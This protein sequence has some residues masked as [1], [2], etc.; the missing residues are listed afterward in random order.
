M[1]SEDIKPSWAEQ[2]ELG[3]D[4]IVLL[5]PT[6][7]SPRINFDNRTKSKTI[8][9]FKVNEDGKK[10]KIVRTYKLE[11][12]K[13]SK[14]ISRRKAWKKFGSAEDDPPGPNPANTVISEDV[15]MQFVHS[16]EAQLSTDQ[17]DDPL[18]KLKNVKSVM[19]RICKGDHWTTR[20]PYKDTLAPVSEADNAEKTGEEGGAAAG[21]PPGA[22]PGAAG[23]KGN[24]VAG[25]YVPPNMREGGNKRGESMMASRRGDEAATIRVTNLSE[26]TRE[27]DLQELFRPFGSI[28]RI[29][30]AKDKISGQSKGFAFITF[31]RRE[32]AA[33]AI[34]GVSGFGYDHL[35]LN[36]EWAKPSGT[37]P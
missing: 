7:P 18:N 32:D 15:Y 8:T 11:S 24:T 13:L 9:E 16:K 35:I 3:D 12:K 19:C 5:S 22:P 20:C 25:K 14:S 26:D 6:L 28:G 29:F 10:V 23:A 27:Q 31:H 36:V 1:P 33:R 17:D 2:V 30:L 4:D 34:A 21:A 37:Q